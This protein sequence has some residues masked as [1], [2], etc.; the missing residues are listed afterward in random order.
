MKREELTT[1]SEVLLDC[2]FIIEQ[3][4]ISK[5]LNY[6]V[7]K[8]LCIVSCVSTPFMSLL[9]GHCLDIKL[10]CFSTINF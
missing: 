3:A 5:I 1:V 6:L 10:Y 8:E 2:R 7:L 4:L 9:D